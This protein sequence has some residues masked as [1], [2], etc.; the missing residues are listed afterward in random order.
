[1]DAKFIGNNV[2][3]SGMLLAEE[4]DAKLIL[5]RQPTTFLVPNRFDKIIFVTCATFNGFV[6]YA[7]GP[8]NSA[9]E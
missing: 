6:R 7:V 2:S 3:F 9:A 8:A 5:A 4:R 1:M